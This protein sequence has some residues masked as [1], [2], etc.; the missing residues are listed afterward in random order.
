MDIGF[1]PIL[2]PKD[3]GPRITRFLAFLLSKDESI[4]G[5][6]RRG[7]VFILSIMIINYFE[8]DERKDLLGLIDMRMYLDEIDNVIE[9]RYPGIFEK[10]N[11]AEAERSQAIKEKDYLV[12]KSKD[13]VNDKKKEGKL[14]DKDIEEIFAYIH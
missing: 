4:E 11:R 3:E 10:L 2:A 1:L 8:G 7:I 12:L 6:L 5:E 14:E 13:F 9:Y